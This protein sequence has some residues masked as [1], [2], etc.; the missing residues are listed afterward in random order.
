MTETALVAPTTYL[1]PTYYETRFRRRGLF[2]RR[3]VETTRAYYIPTTAYYPTTYYYPTTFSSTRLV[4]TA[5]VPSEYVVTSSRVGCC[6]TEVVATAAAPAVRSYPSE[7]AP[8]PAATVPREK[9]RH[10]VLADPERAGGGA[11]QLERAA[12]ARPRGGLAARVGERQPS[13]RSRRRSSRARARAVHGRPSQRAPAAIQAGDHAPAAGTPTKAATGG[14]SPVEAVPAR[15]T[16][17]RVE[18]P[19]PVAPADDLEPAP[20]LTNRSRERPGRDSRRSRCSPRREH[21]VPSCE[22][23][24]SAGSRLARYQR[25]GGRRSRHDLQPDQGLR[26]PS[27]PQ[28]RLRAVRRE[29]SR[30]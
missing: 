4:D 13:E 23:S 24:S 11:D 3:L 14:T 2:G 17:G 8:P 27:G 30:W 19:A 18:L 25:A 1:A 26:G 7:Q 16:P 22:T 9:P 10:P 6:G 21:S 20:G 15:P 12:I 5:V 28:R 29:G